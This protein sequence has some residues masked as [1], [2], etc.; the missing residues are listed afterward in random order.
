MRIGSRGL[1]AVAVSLALLLSTCGDRPPVDPLARGAAWLWAQQSADGG[2]HSE[3]YGLLRSG[4][5]LTALV[6]ATLIDVPKEIAPR[7]PGAVE[8]AVEFLATRIDRRGAIGFA[9]DL[10]T[11]YPSY[12]TSL[13]IV[14]LRRAGMRDDLVDRMRAWLVGQQHSAELGWRREDPVFGGFGMGG[15]RPRAPAHGH[16]DL[17]MTRHVLEALGASVRDDALAFLERCQNPDGGFVFSPPFESANKAGR[18]D[19]GWRSYGTTTADGILALMAV[20]IGRDDACVRR[21][22]DWLVGRHGIER[23]PG[24]PPE[25]HSTWASGLR[26]YYLAASSRALA[27][28]GVGEAPPG[29][30]WRQDLQRALREIQGPD[31]S[32]RNPNGIVKEDDPLIATALAVVALTAAR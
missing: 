20:G 6:L 21:A 4:Q 15:E 9:D 18:T 24:F 5:S 26:F 16:L 12:A 31:G 17:S 27:G 8:R 23:V 29:R 14:A 2:W 3:T 30:D 22:A 19:D 11:D 7:P 13:A 32:W 1:R 25:L 10:T 28:L